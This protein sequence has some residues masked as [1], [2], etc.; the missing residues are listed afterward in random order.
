MLVTI[1]V[2]QGPRGPGKAILELPD[3]RVEDLVGC[4]LIWIDG[5]I[6][7]SETGANESI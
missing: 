5:D 7:N 6:V 4:L 3:V 1:P 2:D